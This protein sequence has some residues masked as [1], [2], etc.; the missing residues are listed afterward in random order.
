MNRD[1]AVRLAQQAIKANNKRLIDAVLQRRAD[2]GA[3]PSPKPTEQLPLI[4]VTCATGWE[5]YAVVEELTRTRRYRVRALYRTPGTQAAERLERLLEATEATSPGLLMLHSGMDLTAAERMTEGFRGCDGVV[6]Y[7]TANTAAAGRITNHGK[8]PVGGRVAFMNQVSAALEA[9]RASPSVQHVITLVFP[10]DKVTGIADDAP[11]IPWWI[12][13]RLRF[14]D[15]LRGQGVNVTCIH[16]PAYYFGMHRADPD[17]GVQVRGESSMSRQMIREGYLPGINRP[18]FVVN[19]VDVR[20]VGKW[21]GTVFAHPEVFSGED[22]SIASCVMTG[23]EAVEI[24]ERTNRHGTRFAYKLFPQWVM[25]M[26]SLWAEEVVYPLRYSHWYC[27]RGNG[28]DFAGD[29]DLAD[30]DR[31]HP[32]WTFERKLEDWGI[33]DLRP[34]QDQRA[35]QPGG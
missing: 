1:T 14:S 21:C 17:G 11:P 8:D 29:D 3:E 25:K 18:D 5:C 34:G 27:D 22:L 2:R 26:L 9:L 13:Q 4:A 19:W 20:D 12:D 10:T 30:L 35:A 6:L 23:D 31:V 7:C 33:T 24:A 28:Y 16:R 32:R 15:F